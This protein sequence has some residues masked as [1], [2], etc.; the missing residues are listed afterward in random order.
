MVGSACCSQKG[1]SFEEGFAVAINMSR[2]LR[3][4]KTVIH[5]CFGIPKYV[6]SISLSLEPSRGH[7]GKYQTKEDESNFKQSSTNF[8]VPTN[9]ERCATTFEEGD[10]G[11]KKFTELKN[12]DI[13]I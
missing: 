7:F 9:N 1:N 13:C 2:P 5:I 3:P 4:V 8:R 10:I 11:K 12:L 6:D